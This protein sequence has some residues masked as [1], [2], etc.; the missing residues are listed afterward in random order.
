MILLLMIVAAALILILEDQGQR[1]DV[2]AEDGL[3][4]SSRPTTASATI[5]AMR[6]PMATS[7]P[8][9]ASTPT[10]QQATE[11]PVPALADESL[12]PSEGQPPPL[13]EWLH[14]D[15]GTQVLALVNAER[16]ERGLLEFSA[17]DAL[18]R[19]AK[20]YARTL[21]R[22]DLLSHTADG[23]DLLSRVR[24][25]GY[26][27]GPPLGEILWRGVGALSPEDTVA[28]WMSSPAHRA[29]ILDPGYR[30]AG[31]GC[32]VRDDGAVL[33]VRCVVDVAG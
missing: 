3:T 25:A 21:L 2:R 19:A 10:T 27:G 29:I 11:P 13:K 15:F 17:N 12:P 9:P 20:G 4:V 32:Y 22:L 18:T 30:E 23:T 24:A 33:D 6:R 16:S 14:T 5:T 31:V 28:G 26:G 8:Q 7:T 1:S